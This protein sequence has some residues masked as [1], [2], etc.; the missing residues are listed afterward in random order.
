MK[1]KY[2]CAY[3]DN[4]EIDNNLS[5]PIDQDRMVDCRKFIEI[6]EGRMEEIIENVWNQ[7]PSDYY[8]KLL[9]GGIILTGGGSNMKNIELAFRNYS[10]IEKVRVAKNINVSINCAKGVSIDNNGMLCTALSLIMKADQLSSGR[11]MSEVN[12]LFSSQETD[13]QPVTNTRIGE[14][15]QPGQI[16]TGR[17]RELAEE[18]ARQKAAEEEARRIAEEEAKKAEEERLRRENSLGNKLAKKFKSFT[19]KFLEE[20]E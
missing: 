6:V 20:E 2:G 1:L 11:P 16:P 12:T 5:Y 7:I 8:E 9:L 13:I 15:K 3:T 14:Q 18:A 4:A 17:E 19:K 10:G